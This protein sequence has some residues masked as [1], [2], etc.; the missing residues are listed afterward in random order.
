M[1]RAADNPFAVHRVLRERYRLSETEWTHLLRRLER[2]GWRGAIVGPN[3]SGKTTLLEDLGKRLDASGRRDV[4]LV[5]GADQLS[6]VEWWRLRLRSGGLVIT[7]HKR[8]M[9]PV[10]HECVT[11]PDLL[12]EITASLG[13]PL[14]VAECASLLRRHGGNIRDA[15][16]ELYDRESASPVSHV[17]VL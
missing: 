13:V 10:L 9:L 8:A 1:L 4:Q 2:L 6:R 5:D 16:R 12:R 7:T 15:L 3:G 14:P 11:T 17:G